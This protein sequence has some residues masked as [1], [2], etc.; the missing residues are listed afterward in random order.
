MEHFLYRLSF[1]TAMHM[2]KDTGSRSLDDC[3]MNIHADTI[4]P[5]CVKRPAPAVARL[6]DLF[7]GGRSHIR[8]AALYRR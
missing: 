1:T 5:P 7:A 8:R 2:G 3:R 4:F 6:A